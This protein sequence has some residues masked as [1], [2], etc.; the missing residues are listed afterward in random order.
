MQSIAEVLSIDKEQVE[1]CQWF[2]GKLSVGNHVEGNGVQAR[3]ND[4]NLF[5]KFPVDTPVAVTTRQRL[6]VLVL[7]LKRLTIKL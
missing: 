7:C 2:C 4:S 5:L 1:T 6:V 3:H